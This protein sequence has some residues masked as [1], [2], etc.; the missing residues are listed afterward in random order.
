MEKQYKEI[1]KQGPATGSFYC[2]W[3]ASKQTTHMNVFTVYCSGCGRKLEHD[4]KKQKLPE[5]AELKK[6]SY[7]QPKFMLEQ[8]C[9]V[10]GA[11]SLAYAINEAFPDNKS[12]QFLVAKTLWSNKGT[13]DDGWKLMLML[14]NDKHYDALATVYNAYFSED[15]KYKDQLKKYSEILVREFGDETAANTLRTILQKEGQ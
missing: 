12:I 10:S 1:P 3:C 11:Y 9:P 6:R 2:P 7:E 13:K 15:L 14:A 4:G 5:P 8:V